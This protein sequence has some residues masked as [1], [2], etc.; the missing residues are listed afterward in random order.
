MPAKFIP[1]GP[2]FWTAP[3]IAT[4]D[5]R[6]AAALGADLLINNRPDGEEFGQPR[7]AEIARA[8]EAAG[9]SYAAIPVRGGAIGPREIDAFEDA[10]SRSA[11]GVVAICRTGTR[12][13][14]HWAAARARRGEPIEAIL[15]DAAAAGYDFS[16]R[17]AALAALRPPK[18]E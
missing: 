2:R 3:Q 11:T 6:A 1:L 8:A 5:V 9:L 4:D 13:A 7:G 18:S 15:A 12:S 14:R 16:G 10:L 17:R